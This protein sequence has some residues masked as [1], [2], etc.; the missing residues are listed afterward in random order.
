MT[1]GPA[2]RPRRRPPPYHPRV[3][4]PGKPAHTVREHP[5]VGE[6]A[7]LVR[8]SQR[9]DHRVGRQIAHAQEL[10]LAHPEER[11]V[12]QHERGGEPAEGQEREAHH[13]EQR[14]PPPP[15]PSGHRPFPPCSA[16]F[17]S[18]ASKSGPTRVMSPAPSVNTTSPARTVSARRA[19]SA[20]RSRTATVVAPEI[21]RAHV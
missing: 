12:P 9:R 4:H 1:S 19:V 8:Q 20:A 13:A 18:C 17:P 21:G 7:R 2:S 5:R 11:Y 14:P 15:R 16:L 3:R 6:H 10:D